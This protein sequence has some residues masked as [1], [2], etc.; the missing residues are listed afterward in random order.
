MYT[1]SEI[2]DLLNLP[3]FESDELFKTANE[4]KINTVGNIVFTRALI[5]LSN[6]CIKDCFYCGIRMGNKLTKRYILS[7]KE[8]S[9]TIDYTI[10]S[11]FKSIVIQSGENSSTEFILKVEDILKQIAQQSNNT[12]RVTL[13]MGEHSDDTYKKWQ[14]AGAHRYLLRI[15]TS[16]PKLYSQIHP[17][18]DKH[19]FKQR[20]QCIES[21]KKLG[22]QTGS[23]VMIG[24]PGQSDEDLANDI[25]FLKNLDIDMCG[26]GPF[27]EHEQTPLFNHATIPLLKRFEFSLKMIA[28]L[29][30]AMPDINIAASTA[31]QSVVPNGREQ[32]ILSGANVIMPNITPLHYRELYKLYKN[33]PG[34]N[35]NIEDSI[36]ALSENINAIGHSL[37]LDEWGDSLHYKKEKLHISHVKE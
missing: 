16:N 11:G 34:I 36:T 1:A 5:E 30:L 4:T 8:I 19:S 33:K 10:K 28:L 18:D 35:Q 3:M 12:I 2:T 27:L 32:G 7:D 21:L 26:M 14:D 23:G 31:L 15:E 20:I 13:S 25:L 24:I 37:S 17:H 6:S 29:R 9:K 22:Y